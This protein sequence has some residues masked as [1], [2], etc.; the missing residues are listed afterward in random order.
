MTRVLQSYPP[1][2]L[3]AGNP[4]PFIHKGQLKAKATPLPLLNCRA[5]MQMWQDKLVGADQLVIDTVE[6]EM[7]RLFAEVR[8]TPA[9]LRL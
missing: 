4:P 6:G 7:D 1:M 3:Q 8:S 2:M 5:L 9:F